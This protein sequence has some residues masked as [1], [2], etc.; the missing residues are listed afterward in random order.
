MYTLKK[1]FSKISLGGVRWVEQDLA[2]ALATNVRTMSQVYGQTR[3]VLEHSHEPNVQHLFDFSKEAAVFINR[4]TETM[5][6]GQWFTALENLALPTT[7]FTSMK[8]VKANFADALE[9]GFLVEAVTPGSVPN[10]SVP[11]SERTDLLLT[12]PTLSP[13]L[14]EENVLVSVN[15]FLHRTYAS[16]RGVYVMQG[17]RTCTVSDMN[18]VGIVSLANLG[19]CKIIP[20]TDSMI[21]GLPDADKALETPLYLNVPN[22]DWDTHTAILVL[23]GYPITMGEV[24]KSTGAGSFELNLLR[25]PYIENFLSAEQFMDLRQVR[26]VIDGNRFA[27]TMTSVK[28]A[29]GRAFIRE[30][31]LLSQSFIV[32]IKSPDVY[33]DKVPLETTQHPCVFLHHETVS[34]PAV[35]HDGRLMNY[36]LSLQGDSHVLYVTDGVHDRRR[37]HA[38]QWTNANAIDAVRPNRS[39][40]KAGNCSILEIKKD[41]FV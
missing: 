15:G 14:V 30:L 3:M 32:A 33:T 11:W 21:G 12:H 1:L 6:V 17:G 27:P 23:C 16:D 37:M 41:L 31:L 38:I 20:I 25:Y 28:Q 29:K 34:S 36:L 40:L 9:A 19:G 5:S 39:R 4:F 18:T 26:N 2:T 13:H 8:T 35:F 7:P 10:Q 22:V 24:F